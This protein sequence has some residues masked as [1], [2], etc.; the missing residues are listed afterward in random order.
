MLPVSVTAAA[1]SPWAESC[2]RD[3]GDVVL[4]AF[5]SAEAALSVGCGGGALEGGSSSAVAVSVRGVPAVCGASRLERPCATSTAGGAAAESSVPSGDSA[6][7][8]PGAV[9][10]FFSVGS[11]LGEAAGAVFPAV[12]WDSFWTASVMALVGPSAMRP[13]RRVVCFRIWFLL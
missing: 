6:A 8:S 4:R 13:L 9:A 1:V 12:P 2:P 10:V 3:A 5:R 11:S 7:G